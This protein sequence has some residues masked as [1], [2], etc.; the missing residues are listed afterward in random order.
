MSINDVGFKPPF[1]LDFLGVPDKQPQENER[2]G[3]QSP[4]EFLHPSLSIKQDKTGSV[5]RRAA[6]ALK[7]VFSKTPSPNRSPESDSPLPSTSL[8]S[9]HRS[10]ISGNESMIRHVLEKEKTKRSYI[11][12]TITKAAQTFLKTFSRKG[13]PEQTTKGD[14]LSEREKVWLAFFPESKS[15][16][17]QTQKA[18]QTESS[19]QRMQRSISEESYQSAYSCASGVMHDDDSVDRSVNMTAGEKHPLERYSFMPNGSIRSIK[20][21]D[22]DEGL[23]VSQDTKKMM[24]QLKK[25]GF[26]VHSYTSTFKTVQID[27]EPK[28]KELPK[29]FNFIVKE[30]IKLMGKETSYH[31][32]ISE[33]KQLVR[34]KGK[35]GNVSTMS[36][37][38]PAILIAVC[39]Y[40]VI[41]SKKI[42]SGVNEVFIQFDQPENV[43]K[44]V[45]ILGKESSMVL[46]DDSYHLEIRKCVDDETNSP[47][48]SVRYRNKIS[49]DRIANRRQSISCSMETVL[50]KGSSSLENPRSRVK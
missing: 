25:Y 48:I 20:T 39:H 6:H 35:Q 40:S 38:D 46:Q 23:E 29:D 16:R 49:E 12:N 1:Y 2:T 31:F 44:L 13:S 11:K 18:S 50:Y 27:D 41:K 30:A 9:G 43:N 45:Q 8:S 34:C 3:F 28:S 32:S 10:S 15:E 36:F 17:S 33:E 47:Y 26:Y 19:N 22:S 5:W 37:F 24:S 21:Q 14:I 42:A 4:L 7:K